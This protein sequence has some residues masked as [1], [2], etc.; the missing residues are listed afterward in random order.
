MTK[1]LEKFQIVLKKHSCKNCLFYIIIIC[2]LFNSCRT[3]KEENK[4][5]AIQPFGDVNEKAI[6][7]LK[8]EIEK[9]YHYKVEVLE[10]IELPEESYYKPRNRYKADIL[11]KYLKENK[12][13]KYKYILGITN[14]D[15]STKTRNH[16][17]FGIF[18]LGYCP[19][20]S[21]IISTFRIKHTNKEKVLD[22]ILKIGLHELG[23]NF[24]LRH[25]IDKKCF[26]TDANAS[27]KTIDN[28]KMDLCNK[29]K[30]KLNNSHI[31]IFSKI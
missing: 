29:C 12:K 3:I 27:I 20:K 13:Q 28:A 6:Y 19:G 2:I 16:Q 18:G 24:G 4:Y 7:R 8:E 31:S 11:I 21:C 15:I 22:R 26:M 10:K 5:I 25:C 30:S 17:D 9:Y 23:H 1:E 14:K